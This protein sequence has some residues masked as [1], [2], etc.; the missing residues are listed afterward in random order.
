MNPHT[1]IPNP[2]L[3]LADVDLESAEYGGDPAVVDLTQIAEFAF[4][5][6]V[7]HARTTDKQGTPGSINVNFAFAHEEITPLTAAP[8]ELYTRKTQITCV[9]G[10]QTGSGSTRQFASARVPISGRY[11]YVWWETPGG[12]AGDTIDLKV[13]AQAVK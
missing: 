2:V 12:T 8:A 1:L 4:E 5:G 10:D 13:W 11:L 7:V 6:I 3:D 9:L